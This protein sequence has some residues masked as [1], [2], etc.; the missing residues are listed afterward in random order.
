MV[1]T[2]ELFVT[3]HRARMRGYLQAFD[4]ALAGMGDS[5]GGLGDVGSKRG[6]EQDET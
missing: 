4:S 5:A 3:A 6:R 1:E 2:E